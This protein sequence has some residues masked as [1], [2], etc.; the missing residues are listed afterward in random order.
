MI[1]PDLDQQELEVYHT[2]DGK[3]VTVK[4]P[5]FPTMFIEP[6]QALDFALTLSINVGHCEEITARKA[7]EEA[8]SVKFEVVK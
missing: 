6:N 1:A 4:I 5:G 2:E 8:A 7:A 3:H